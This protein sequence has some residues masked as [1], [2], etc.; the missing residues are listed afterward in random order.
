MCA[1]LVLGLHEPQVDPDASLRS[2]LLGHNSPLRTLDRR[3]CARKEITVS[4]PWTMV[5][6]GSLLL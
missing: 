4:A 6:A 3:T 2:L 5:L 1:P